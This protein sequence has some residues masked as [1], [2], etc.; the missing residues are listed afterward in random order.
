MNTLPFLILSGALIAGGIAIFGGLAWRIS[1][2]GNA[3]RYEEHNY[4]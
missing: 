4:D 1:S 3:P 2:R